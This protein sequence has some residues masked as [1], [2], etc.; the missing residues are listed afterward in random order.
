MN[1]FELI[2]KIESDIKEVSIR[3]NLESISTSNLLNYLNQ[4]REGVLAINQA[5]RELRARDLEYVKLNHQSNIEEYKAK[6]ANGLELFKSVISYGQAALNSAILVNGAAAAAI[7]A[8]IG[9]LWGKSPEPAAIIGL[10]S[11]VKDFARGAF[12]AAIGTGIT[13]LCQSC[14]SHEKNRIGVFFQVL[15]VVFVLLS[16]YMFFSGTEEA[17]KAFLSQLK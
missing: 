1:E 8:L 10:A 6:V 13:Y 14:Y 2:R 11:S 4:I 17:H 3:E 16:Y 5:E 7:L 9:N 12:L 15:A